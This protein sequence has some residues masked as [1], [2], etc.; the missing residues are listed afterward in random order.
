[1]LA[2]HVLSAIST[3]VFGFIPEC[4]I[5]SFLICFSHRRYTGFTRS[6]WVVFFYPCSIAGDMR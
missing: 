3:G 6:K 2:S 1:M 4:F 5:F